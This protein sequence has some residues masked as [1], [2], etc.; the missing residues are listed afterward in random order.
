MLLQ[1]FMVQ[2]VSFADSS[3]RPVPSGKFSQMLTVA[4]IGD[5]DNIS[6]KDKCPPYGISMMI[7]SHIDKSR[8]LPQSLPVNSVGVCVLVINCCRPLEAIDQPFSLMV[9]TTYHDGILSLVNQGLSQRWHEWSLRETS[10]S[11][12]RLVSL[13]PGHNRASGPVIRVD[14]P[15]PLVAIPRRYIG[16]IAGG[17]TYLTRDWTDT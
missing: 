17:R 7:D 2:A 4:L 12:P 3:R 9:L 1:N 14:F 6:P 16:N 13:P 10:R 11:G 5:E 8:I 15:P